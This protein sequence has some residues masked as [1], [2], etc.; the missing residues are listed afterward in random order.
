MSGRY[1]GVEVFGTWCKDAYPFRWIDAYRAR[2]RRDAVTGLSLP[3]APTP[4]GACVFRETTRGYGDLPGGS[5]RNSHWAEVQSALVQTGFLRSAPARG[6]ASLAR[7]SMVGRDSGRGAMERSSGRM[8]SRSRHRRVAA[9]SDAEATSTASGA[10]A[11]VAGPVV[12]EGSVSVRARVVP[13]VHP[14]IRALLEEADRA[15]F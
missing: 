13:E 2:F 10:P 4:T 8:R 1:S 6:D 9:D 12:P 15:G 14:A 5:F 11:V 7:E 3:F